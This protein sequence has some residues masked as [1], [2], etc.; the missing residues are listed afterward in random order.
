M[1]NLLNSQFLGWISKN[2][3]TF[4]LVV[5]LSGN[6]Y[7]YLDAKSAQDTCEVKMKDMGQKLEELNKENIEY[8]RKRSEE[9][10]LLLS[11]L[12]K[13]ESN[14]GYNDRSPQVHSTH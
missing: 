10:Q 11:N 4:M 13:I 3:A 8:E 5:L 1:V 7:Q 14:A 12:S 9:L 2:R 6:I